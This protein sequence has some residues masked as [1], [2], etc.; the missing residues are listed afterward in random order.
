MGVMHALWGVTFASARDLQV[1][2]AHLHVWQRML[3]DSDDSW[4]SCG[5]FMYFSPSPRG[6][7]ATLPDVAASGDPN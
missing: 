5:S 6:L 7:S 3:E 1:F 2:L 4:P